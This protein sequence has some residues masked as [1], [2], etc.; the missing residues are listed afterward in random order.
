[1]EY[2]KCCLTRKLDYKFLEGKNDAFPHLFTESLDNA[3]E[4]LKSRKKKYICGFQMTAEAY[5]QTV[6]SFVA[7]KGQQIQM[8]Y[9][10][11]VYLKPI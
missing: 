9:Y 3:Q 10:R 8:M 11:I 2:F 1:M 4:V 7:F 5:E 6:M